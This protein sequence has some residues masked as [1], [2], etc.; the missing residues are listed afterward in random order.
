MWV[1]D[2]LLDRVKFKVIDATGF[3]LQ[4]S[5]FYMGKDK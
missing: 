3:Y 4:D 2:P 1:V 5:W